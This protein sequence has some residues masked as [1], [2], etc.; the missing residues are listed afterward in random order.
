MLYEVL[1]QPQDNIESVYDYVSICEYVAFGTFLGTKSFKRHK[2]VVELENLAH[3]LENSSQN[4]SKVFCFTYNPV[5]DSATAVK[6]VDAVL[7]R[8]FSQTI[9]N[10]SGIVIPLNNPP[11]DLYTSKALKEHPKVFSYSYSLKGGINHNARGQKIAK[12][13]GFKFR[14]YMIQPGLFWRKLNQFQR[15]SFPDILSNFFDLEPIA[16]EEDLS[17]LGDTVLLSYLGKEIFGPLSQ[18]NCTMKSDQELASWIIKKFTTPTSITIANH[19]WE[20]WI[21]SKNK[22]FENHLFETVYNELNSYHI[23]DYKRKLRV[24]LLKNIHHRHYLQNIYVHK[25]HNNPILPF[26]S[27]DI[28]NFFNLI[29]EDLLNEGRFLDKLCFG[30]QKSEV[31]LHSYKSDKNKS[32]SSLFKHLFFNP[33]P[34]RIQHLWELNFKGEN[35]LKRLK[36]F[37]E[38]RKDNILPKSL[39]DQAVSDFENQPNSHT[40]QIINTFTSISSVQT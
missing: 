15:D 33:Q 20:Y 13:F 6:K 31:P 11:I 8:I 12:S 37:F 25:L 19:L 7:K 38:E 26:Y 17:Y 18:I 21:G 35:N 22:G 5:L 32:I 27:I 23:S 36:H 16:Y 34:N 1:P 4:Q 2:R 28:L 9:H 40:A 3:S 14:Q 29:P 10:K 30:E 39:I 24:F